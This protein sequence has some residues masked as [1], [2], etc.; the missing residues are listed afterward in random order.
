V[1]RKGGLDGDHI[2]G[3]CIPY[4]VDLRFISSPWLTS[5]TQNPDDISEE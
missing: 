3:K 4:I 5:P 2:G 1:R